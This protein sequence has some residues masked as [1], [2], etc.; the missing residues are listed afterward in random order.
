MLVV[1]IKADDI[2]FSNDM[3]ERF[4]KKMGATIEKRS[5]CLLCGGEIKW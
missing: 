5:E 2:Y 1:E 4:V 3:R